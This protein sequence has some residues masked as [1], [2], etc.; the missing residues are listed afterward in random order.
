MVNAID[1]RGGEQA[2]TRTEIHMKMS[3][4][5][6]NEVRPTLQADTS[7]LNIIVQDINPL[8]SSVI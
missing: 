7:T 1:C 3:Y 6:C 2:S 8:K 4:L 5:L